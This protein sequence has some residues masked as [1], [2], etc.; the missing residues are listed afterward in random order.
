M[1]KGNLRQST[2]KGN[3]IQG[4]TKKIIS[5]NRDKSHVKIKICKN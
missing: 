4:I 1:V 3:P 2:C 5:I